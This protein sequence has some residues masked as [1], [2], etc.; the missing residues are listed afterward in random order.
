MLYKRTY[1]QA[2]QNQFE[3]VPVR[4]IIEVERIFKVEA[5]VFVEEFETHLPGTNANVKYKSSLFI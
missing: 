5:F 3:N 2:M 1:K 4:H